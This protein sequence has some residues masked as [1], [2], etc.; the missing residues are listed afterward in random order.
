M[1]CLLVL[2]L[3]SHNLRCNEGRFI[4]K[5]NAKI[6][7]EKMTVLQSLFLWNMNYKFSNAGKELDILLL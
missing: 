4:R 3:C 1:F 6:C 7:I 5:R 2:L